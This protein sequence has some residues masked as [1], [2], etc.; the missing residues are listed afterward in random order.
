MTVQKIVPV[1]SALMLVLLAQQSS[2]QLEEV[3]VTA[4]KR[5]ES[6]QDVS[7]S[8]SVVTGEKL[9]DQGIS[10]VEELSVYI[11]N[12]TLSET[13]IGTQLFVRG[14]GSGIN[15]GFEQSVG[16]YVDG[17]Y[18]GRAQLTRSPFFDMDRIEVLRGPQVTLFGNN[19][20][21][22]ALSLNTV[23][24]SQESEASVSALYS[25]EYGET[26]FTL[27][28]GGALT[29]NISARVAYRKFDL[30]GY[31]YNESLDR[32]EPQRDFE[33][34]RASFKVEFSDAIDSTLK[35][36]RSNFDV[37]GRQIAVLG[38]I[39][40]S[41]GAGSSTSG[42]SFAGGNV[43]SPTANMTLAEIYNNQN[44]F[45][46]TDYLAADGNSLVF[47][48]DGSSRYSNGDYSDNT[49]NNVTLTTRFALPAEYELSMI[50]G[51][52]DYEYDEVCD[53]DFSGLLL[54][55]YNTMEDYQQQSL[56]LRF[57]SPGGQTVDLI[58]GIYL[59]KDTLDYDDQLRIPE[60]GSAIQDVVAGIASVAALAPDLASVNVPRRFDQDNEQQAIFGQLTWNLADNFRVMVGARRSHY[61]KEATRIMDFVN[62]D[63][64]LP[65]DNAGSALAPGGGS[66]L[67][68]L[69]FLFGSVFGAY[70]HTEEGERERYKTSYNVIAEWDLSDDILLYTSLTEGF[71]AGGYDVRANSPTSSNKQ[72][73]NASIP[74]S[75]P[76]TF[77]FDDEEITAYEA[78]AKM[79][80]SD[81][82]ELNMAYFYTEI[83]S[84]Q[85]STF[86]GSVGFNVTNAGRARTQGVEAELRVALT[87]NLLLMASVGTLDFEFLDYENGSCIG[88]DELIIQNNLQLPLQRNCR[89]QIDSNSR[90][91]LSDMKGETN[92]YVADYSGLLSLAYN[93]EVFGVL[94]FNGSIDYSFTDEYFAN[95]NLDPNMKQP[96]YGK[97][98]IRLALSD[99]DEQWTAALLVRNATDETTIGFANNVPL[100][101][102]QF[103]APSYYAFY[104]QGRSWALQLKYNF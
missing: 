81:S 88:S 2:A 104:D 95:E 23:A 42:F 84:L 71:K 52:L 69:D 30:D 62:T 76:G 13:G 49:T 83:D 75:R 21:G 63:G 86:D 64:S 22:G 65:D 93:R 47:S 7:V 28:A 3:I 73:D 5:A 103:A 26:E 90:A 25:P 40:N 18:Y 27:I 34:L 67:E 94:Q 87:D 61:K 9:S 41:F 60:T 58:G 44:F 92:I 53:C 17:I 91:Y 100:A 72:P 24:P 59:Q 43:P 66:R 46:N 36:E 80:L 50:Y 12:L 37:E 20:I 45:G 14:I 31:L 56:E 98:N 102:S 48:P 54:F 97:F 55:D 101:T 38:G 16:T 33:T 77:E 82:V 35:L 8:V 79:R 6:L 32:D 74:V 96:A 68:S 10:R 15:Q 57:T 51:Y 99:L 78:G 19:S 89:L 39:K 11:P 1:V 29:D 85:V 70:R 4:Q